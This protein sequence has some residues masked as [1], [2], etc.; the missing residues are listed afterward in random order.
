MADDPIPERRMPPHLPEQPRELGFNRL[1]ASDETERNTVA[2]SAPGLTTASPSAKISVAIHQPPPKPQPDAFYSATFD[3]PAYQAATMQPKVSNAVLATSGLTE[4]LAPPQ[5]IIV[6]SR[7]ALENTLTMSVSRAGSSAPIAQSAVER[8]IAERAS[9]IRDAAHAL[10]KAFTE[11][12]DLLRKSKPNDPARLPDY[13]DL[14]AFFER[15][16]SGLAKLA[17]TLDELM[18]AVASKSDREPL[19]LGKAA[20]IAEQLNIGLMEWLEQNR[21]K[22]FDYPIKLSLFAGSLLFL[23]HFAIDTDTVLKIVG[24]YILGRASSGSQSR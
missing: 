3:A 14:V 7:H 12:L 5:P 9:D 20:E 16:A 21:S 18:E 6:E 11:Q 22:V 19:F 23:H 15:M 13:E 24:G 8:R 17:G 2:L 4:P 10:S 1:S